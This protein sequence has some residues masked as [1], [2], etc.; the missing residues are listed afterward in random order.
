MTFMIRPNRVLRR[1]CPQ[2]LINSLISTD[3]K[4]HPAAVTTAYSAVVTPRSLRSRATGDLVMTTSLMAHCRWASNVVARLWPAA[5]ARERARFEAGDGPGEASGCGE[6]LAVSTAGEYGDGSRHERHDTHE[7][8]GRQQAD[9]EWDGG[10]DADRP[11]TGLQ[12]GTT[13]PAEVVG[14]P[15]HRVRNR[16]PA[17]DGPGERATE[18]P[19]LRVDGEVPPDGDRVDTH[20]QPGRDC[21]Q[22][23]GHWRLER[24][25]D[26]L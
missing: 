2:S 24:L 21:R 13:V 19:E 3:A 11:R 18:A 1:D 22:L 17:L 14:Q 20:A 26:L 16:C 5:G 25:D 9:A 7:N 15:E 4:P 23:L 12:V 6:E 8:E 10:L